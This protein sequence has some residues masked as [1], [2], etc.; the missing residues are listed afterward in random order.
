MTTNIE[1]VT[2]GASIGDELLGGSAEAKYVFEVASGSFWKLLPSAQ[3]GDEEEWIKLREGA[4]RRELASTGL[5]QKVEGGAKQSAVDARLHEI[6][7]QQRVME[8]RR[9]AGYRAGIHEIGNDRVLVPRALRLLKR[10]EGPWLCVAAMV[11]GLFDGD[12]WD[13]DEH[14]KDRA[15]RFDQRDYVFAWL[16]DLLR[17]L[18][19]GK[20]TSGS[21]F[22]LAGVRDCGKTRWRNVLRVLSGDRVALPYAWMIGQDSFNRELFEAALWVID[23]ET[24]DTSREARAKVGA[25]MKKIAAGEELKLRG[26]QSD[27]FNVM[28]TRRMFFSLNMG[29]NDLKVLPQ[30]AD[31]VA[32]KLSLF[33]GYA[34]PRVPTDPVELER[35]R[36]RYPALS[37]WWDWAIEKKI[38]GEGDIV[39]C[40]PMP[41][42]AAT[43]Y[44][45][46]TFWQ[47]IMG[48]LPAFAHWLTEVYVPPSHVAE[49]RFRVKVWHHPEIVEALRGFDPHVQLWSSMLK[50]GVVWRELLGRDEQG[51]NQWSDREVWSGDAEALHDLLT[52][53]TSAL[54]DI[55]KRGVPG[56]SYLGI[57]LHEAASHWG[58]G[59]AK[60]K[61]SG[62]ERTWH[63]RK[64]PDQTATEA[65]RRHAVTANDGK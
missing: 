41:M 29:E 17:S 8:A 34:R 57:R 4:M 35:Y 24:V 14:G 65:A 48:E 47:R 11:E 18:Y 20:V 54:S 23:D 42:P 55:E 6:E 50:S 44:E 64:S 45:Q 2:G 38:M 25:W 37:A 33:K 62:R 26:I 59:V 30:L 21:A 63:L 43:L 5:S 9:L 13:N 53:P 58:E 16:Q 60:L 40:W 46:E 32:D 61:R 51:D 10:A 56:P 31:G 28:T 19:D 27:G 3:A 1:P 36:A 39:R 15:K 49:G 7:Q 22:C 52:G 12:D